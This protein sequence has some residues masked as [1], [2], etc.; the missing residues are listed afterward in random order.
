MG[1]EGF[2]PAVAAVQPRSS[3]PWRTSPRTSES[4]G[5][6]GWWWWL[7]LGSARRAAS[8]ISGKT[9]RY[10]FIAGNGKYQVNSR[11]LVTYFPHRSPGSGLYDNLQ[12]YDL[13]YA[14]AIFEIGFFHQ[15]PNP[16]F[17]LAKELYPGNY[18]PNLTHY[19]VRLLHEKGQLLRMYTQNID[20]LE[21]RVYFLKSSLILALFLYC[22]IAAK[23]L[24]IIEIVLSQCLC[25]CIKWQGFLLRC[26]WRLTVRL[27]PPP[28]PPAWG[29]MRERSSEWVLTQTSTPAPRFTGIFKIL[30][31]MSNFS[32]GEH[33]AHSSEWKPAVHFNTLYLFG[34]LY[35]EEV[36]DTHMLIRLNTDVRLA[37][38][39]FS[40]TGP[41][42]N[43]LV[44]IIC[45][46]LMQHLHCIYRGTVVFLIPALF[47]LLQDTA[48]QSTSLYFWLNFEKLP[49]IFVFF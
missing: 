5:T 14:E 37:I 30:F 31:I 40:K 49:H 10:G 43:K 26:W 17:A 28:A 8:Q 23:W 46:I 36:K 42:S 27:P 47:Q 32:P 24:H 38:Y 7:E 15:N 48:V 45:P 33:K 34:S 20:G 6:R 1:F 35:W 18:Q 11:S 44:S 21:R 29:D 4:S 16:F 19:F 3:R 9:I 2:S 25:L 22:F 41:T 12:Q 39:L 13:P